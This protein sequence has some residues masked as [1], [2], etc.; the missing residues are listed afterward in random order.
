MKTIILRPSL[1]SEYSNRVKELEKAFKEMVL[2]DKTVCEDMIVYI[3]RKKIF[4]KIWR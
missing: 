3:F 4:K 1:D 2:E